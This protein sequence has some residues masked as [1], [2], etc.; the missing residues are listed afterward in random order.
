[1]ERPVSLDAEDVR[2]E[3]VK[4]LRAITPV[5][6][7]DVLLGQYTKS[8]DGT[9]PGYLDDK[10]VPAGSKTPTYAV[11]VLKIF[12]ERWDGVPFFLRCGKALNDGKAEIRIQFKTVAGS[13][14]DDIAR[15]ELVIRV[16]PNEA[17]YIKMMNKLPGLSVNPTIS[18]LDLSYGR[19]YSDLIIPDAYE[20]LILDC[21]KGDH[22]NFVRDDELDAAW[23]IFTPILH[24]IDNGNI[25]PEVYPYGS[26]GPESAAE[27]IEKHGYVRH[28]QE[29]KWG[30]QPKL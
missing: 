3:K 25:V 26:R 22:S 23:K 9:K 19:R 13:I 21:I 11:A 6:A 12:N 29:Y 15:N 2:D 30:E 24:Q 14:F 4:V 8:V 16:Q 18:E 10:T 27:F 5:E 7:K 28:T 20:S 1:M 17:V